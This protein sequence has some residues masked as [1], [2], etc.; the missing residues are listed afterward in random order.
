ML[1]S[2]AKSENVKTQWRPWP[3]FLPRNFNLLTPVDLAYM[4][5]TDIALIRGEDHMG[6][7]NEDKSKEAS[8]A[9]EAPVVTTTP[10]EA[11]H[12][13][14]GTPGFLPL[15][16]AVAQ[17][18]TE[19]SNP[20]WKGVD[21]EL[22]A[23]RP[24]V[25][26]VD[27]PYD[28]KQ[29]PMVINFPVGHAV[30]FSASGWGKTTFLRTVITSLVSTHSPDE[31]NI[32]IVDFGGRNL[33]VFK[34]LPHVG[35]F[36]TSEEEERI[37]RLLR[38]IESIVEKRQALLSEAGIVD[39]YTYNSKNPHNILPAILVVVDNFAG[40][41]ENYENLLPTVIALVRESRA[42]GVHFVLTAD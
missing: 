15:N 25:G 42:Y 23:M 30:L 22:I 28:A 17:W 4:G 29:L 14:D 12:S 39:I 27:N 6:G 8:S 38:R 32:Y 31:L 41:R 37:Q 5:E 35:A 16:A 19:G 3:A 7:I 21:W 10:S 9:L 33:A 18:V 20:Q 36:I 13:K 26:L 34:D 1:S 24:L 40:F 2:L 11:A